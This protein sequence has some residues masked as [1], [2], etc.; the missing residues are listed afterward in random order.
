MKKETTKEEIIK[1]FAKKDSKNNLVGIAPPQE[2]PKPI[3]KPVVKQPDVEKKNEVS[4]V[5]EKIDNSFKNTLAAL[6]MQKNPVHAAKR[7]S[8]VK[9][10]PQE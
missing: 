8:I 5:A 9:T 2:Q 3:S 1:E 10:K 6:L 7:G 4:R